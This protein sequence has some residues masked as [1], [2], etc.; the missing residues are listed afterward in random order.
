M[1]NL[2]KKI[3]VLLNDVSYLF[4]KE[5]PRCDKRGLFLDYLRIR[6]KSSL[7]RWMHFKSEHFLS[8]TVDVL[9]YNIFLAEFRQI[10][11]RQVYYP[12]TPASSPRIFDCGGNIGISVLYWKHVFPDAQV[13]VFEPSKE[14]V[15]VLKKNIEANNLTDIRVVESAVS[16]KEGTAKIYIRGSIAEGNTL[17]QDI[18]S[19]TPT[20]GNR[21]SYEIQT[22]KLS[23]FI[24]GPIDVLKL[25]IE[26][27]EGTVIRELSQA[28]KLKLVGE[29]VM[30][31]HY[32][33]TAP[34]NA[35]PALLAEL[36]NAGFETQFYFEEH[37]SN[38]QFELMKHGSYVFNIRTSPTAALS[39][40]YA[41]LSHATEA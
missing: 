18:W 15:E 16:D 2:S 34:D 14:V 25:D 22:V 38:V 12:T 19:A 6:A 3:L 24:D 10:F 30:E 21:V 5:Y 9:D 17:S 20:K 13:T 27:S 41:A 1:R 40:Q 4:S 23:D 33:P 35:L 7:N 31:F 32:Y 28:G 29:C 11:V 26:G 36:N 37:P 39:D 8:Y